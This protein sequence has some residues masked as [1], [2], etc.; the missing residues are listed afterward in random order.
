M[1]NSYDLPILLLITKDNAKISFFKRILKSTFYVI[2][3]ADGTA[4]VDWLKNLSIDTVVFDEKSADTPLF[5]FCEHAHHLKGY[6]SLPILLITSNQAKAFTTKALNAGVADFLQEPLDEKE[7]YR[8]IAVAQ[9]SKVVSQKMVQVAKK[10]KKTQSAPKEELFLH[11]FLLSDQALKEISQAKKI[12]TPLSLVMAQIDDFRDI[13]KSWGD[14]IGEELLHQV[15][16]F[17]KGKLRKFDSL[18]PQGSGKFLM[19]LPKTSQRAAVAISDMIRN[20]ISKTEFDTQKNPFTVTVSMG[21][22]AFDQKLSDAA[23][24]YEQFDKLLDK[25]NESLKEAQK[26]GNQIVSKENP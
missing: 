25:V 26:K 15:E 5:N 14:L 4:A 9:K 10:L 6:E 24:A 13:Q 22:V 8:R 18:F 3:A 12:A 17:L 16:L 21:I 7:V 2:E 20:E 23:Q 11:R 19:L 1:E